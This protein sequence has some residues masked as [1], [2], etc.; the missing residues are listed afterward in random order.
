MQR[1]IIRRLFH[2]VILV[3]LAVTAVFFMLRLT[4][5]PVLLFA[6]MDTSA[7]DLDE[8]WMELQTGL[9]G[10]ST[11][12]RQE[13]IAGATHDQPFEKPDVIVDAIREVKGETGG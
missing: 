6:P 12:G 11:A 3:F 2:G 8:I 9:V 10:L 1:F 13:I 5:D 4:G 7:K